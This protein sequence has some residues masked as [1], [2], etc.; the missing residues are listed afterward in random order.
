MG[1]KWVKYRRRRGI[2]REKGRDRNGNREG[3]GHD[4][5]REGRREGEG[6][7]EGEGR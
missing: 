3:V 2:M 7:E 1:D 6:H 4:R 5:G